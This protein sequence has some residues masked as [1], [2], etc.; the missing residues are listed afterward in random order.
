MEIEDSL[1]EILSTIIVQLLNNKNI[2]NA[3][4]ECFMIS[5][6]LFILIFSIHD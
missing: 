6:W 3:I 5:N 1:A 4:A 2:G